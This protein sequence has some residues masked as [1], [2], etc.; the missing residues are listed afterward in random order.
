M[1]CMMQSPLLAQTDFTN[2]IVNPSFELN[3]LSG[4]TNKGYQTQTND[5]PTAQGWTKDGTTYA[6]K[7]SNS[8]LADG[9]LSQVVEGLPDGYYIVKAD[10]HAYVNETGLKAIG[11]YL[12][13]G[14][15]QRVVREG[16]TYRVGAIVTGGKIEIG[17]RNTNTN[18]TWVGVDHFRIEKGDTTIVNY[19]RYM[20]TVRSAAEDLQAQAMQKNF[21]LPP[22]LTDAIA[23]SDN[24]GDDKEAIIAAVG[25]MEQAISDYSAIMP[26]YTRLQSRISMARN[27]MLRTDYKGKSDLKSAISNAVAV[28]ATESDVTRVD[29]QNQILRQALDNYLANRPSEWI[30]IQNGKLW[31][32]ANRQITVQAH[33]PGF[34]RVGDL[35]YMVGEDRS[36][37]W[38]PD[39]NLYSSTD[40]INWKFEKKIIQNG[41]TD[42]RLGSS[43]MIE[44]A[45]LMYNEKTEKFVVWCHWES[46]NYGA[47]EA[48][49]FTC[50]SVNGAYKLEWC[51]RPL[52]VKS[53]D[54]N[55]FQDTDGTAYFISTT[56]E[57]QHLGL[58]RLS[59]DYLRVEEHT[60]LFAWQ[61]REAPAIVR[62]SSRYFMF[63]SACSGWDPNQCKL[64]YSNSLESGWS[65]LKNVGN[66]IAYDTQAAAIL[67]IRGTKQT[68][69][70]YVGD[71]W[72]DPDLPNTKT[73]M[74]PI[75]FNGTSCEFKYR[76]RFDI[77]FVTGEW[78]ETPTDE[79]FVDKTGWKVIDSS[80]QETSSENSPAHN[81]ID[82]NVNT[83]WHTRYSGNGA[84][85]PHHITI[86][87]GREHAINGF[88][89]TPRMDGATNGL[90]RKYQFQV[91]NDGEE[92][93]TVSSGDWLPYCA[94]V[95][96]TEQNCRYIKLICMEGTYA[97]LAE[98]DVVIAPS[99]TTAIGQPYTPETNK[100][101]I[102]HRCF[103]SL[104]GR[105]ITHP[106]QGVFI[107]QLLYS[108]GT[109]KN[110]KRLNKQER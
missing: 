4:W 9:Q 61:R 72:Q 63:S 37:T 110:V 7:W 81:A 3:G 34:V 40:F 103:F 50:D 62:L 27:N 46:S 58:F 38:N 73:I 106:T 54:C 25:Q 79:V 64:S 1:V 96:F 26:H 19:K 75:T 31:K 6:E 52:D 108:D 69:Y 84:S 57:N 99:E 47:S 8:A 35:W 100:K 89:A 44:R 83:K 85:A 14:R 77:N 91:S 12:F 2:R 32:A 74:F 24:T 33:A 5:S 45:K 94:E 29:E 87:M 48:A 71:R 42:S 70:L 16:Q 66:A 109:C 22:S 49:C 56:E 101:E 13:A 105:K 21:Y 39:V 86:D 18:A 88:L 65:D 98:L 80:S 68:T 95:S 10:A 102:K 15:G 51:G 23:A 67:E 82:G 92:W 76:E 107:E 55:I 20:R 17:I 28:L 53:R 60:R 59:D 43:R 93:S 30:T 41:V 11:A 36:N 97:S 104:D 90:I 78:R